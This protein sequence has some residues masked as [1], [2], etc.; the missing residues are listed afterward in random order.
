MAAIR[1]ASVAAPIGIVAANSYTARGVVS[2][3][4]RRWGS[5]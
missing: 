1:L 2:G 5:V 3:P 4:C